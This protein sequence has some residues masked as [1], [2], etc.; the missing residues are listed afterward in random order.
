[1]AI[2]YQIIDAGLQWSDKYRHFCREAYM[3][4]YVRPEL[5]ITE[6]QFSKNVFNSPRVKK[7]FDDAFNAGKD[8]KAWLALQGNEILGGVVAYD[9][10]DYCEMQTFYVKHS[11]RGHGIGHALYIKVLEFA[12]DLPIQ[13]DVVLYLDQ[14][15][16]MYKHWGFEVDDSKGEVEYDWI[17]WPEKSRES[18]KGIYMVK[19]GRNN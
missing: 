8:H 10:G 2:N 13:V 7:Y 4:T 14:T 5:G 11:L 9:Y 18:Y 3:Q 17:E 15:I 16:A 6:A 12:G 19:P 1:M